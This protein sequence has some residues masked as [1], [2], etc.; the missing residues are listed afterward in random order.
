MTDSYRGPRSRWAE[1]FEEG[2]AL[3]MFRPGE[4]PGQAKKLRN[5]WSGNGP[6]P[7]R[8]FPSRCRKAQVS[9]VSQKHAAL[10][11]TFVRRDA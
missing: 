2:I 3:T 8:R 9:V 1:R 11:R 5:A 7:A 10:V 4:N 6:C